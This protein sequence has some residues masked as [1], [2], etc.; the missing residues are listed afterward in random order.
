MFVEFAF[1]LIALSAKADVRVDT[2]VPLQVT[3]Q[4]IFVHKFGITNIA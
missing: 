2:Q 4:V 1:K 3:F